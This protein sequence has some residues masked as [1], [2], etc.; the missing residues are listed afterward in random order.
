MVMCARRRIE[1]G[2]L[3]DIPPPLG[4]LTPHAWQIVV[5]ARAQLERDTIPGLSLHSIAAELGISTP[6][7]YRHVT[8]KHMLETQLIAWGLWE[9]GEAMQS[10]AAAATDPVW[11]LMMAHRRFALTN[12]ELY[13]LMTSRSISDPVVKAA[14]LNTRVA[15]TDNVEAS[16]RRKLL[17]A[18]GHGLVM[19]EMNDRIPPGWDIEEMWRE[20][21]ALLRAA[22]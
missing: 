19:L 18:F 15:L 4:E 22:E 5:V 11:D 1:P 7:L 21:V 3:P 2:S 16:L 12:P 9:H 10:G 20:G 8:G 17:W 13:K 14:E 6:S